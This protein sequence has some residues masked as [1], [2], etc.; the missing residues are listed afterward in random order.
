[1]VEQGRSNPLG[2]GDGSIAD[3]VRNLQE[4]AS[5]SG[6]IINPE[7]Q[8]IQEPT[9]AELVRQLGQVRAKAKA[10][11]YSRENYPCLSCSAFHRKT[12]EDLL[13]SCLGK[14]WILRTSPRN[15]TRKSRLCIAPLIKDGKS[16]SKNEGQ[17]ISNYQTFFDT[18][19]LLQS[20]CSELH[21]RG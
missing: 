1:M 2:N 18:T 5:F 11:R 17:M 3:H 10:L 15:K 9:E 6:G 14:R 7:T 12:T 20:V 4:Q 13:Q 16:S 8:G 19:I 21:L